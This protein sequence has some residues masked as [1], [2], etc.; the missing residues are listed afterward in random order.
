[1]R[2]TKLGLGLAL[3][4]L[5]VG[6]VLGATVLREPI[7]YAASPFQNV[8]VAN[9]DDD[10]VPVKVASGSARVPVES[11][12]PPLWQGTPYVGSNVIFGS[13][14]DDLPAVPAGKVLYIQHATVSYN[15]A[16]GRSAIGAVAL[17]PLGGGPQ[18]IYIPAHPSGAVHQAFGVYD[19]YMGSDDIGLPT[20]TTP[21]ACLFATAEDDVRGRV[22]VAGYLLD[23][24]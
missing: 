18:F 10:P 21:Q 1:M 17:T 12:P 22:M 5:V 19:G 9:T 13:D 16:P 8:I 2:H 15:V 14:C 4:V 6:A 24:R 3:L 20:A 7:A 11:P 23:A